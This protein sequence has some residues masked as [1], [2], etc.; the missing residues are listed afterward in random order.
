LHA[1]Q[2]WWDHILSPT[3]HNPYLRT[4]YNEY[5][6]GSWRICCPVKILAE[7]S[8]CKAHHMT[9]I[10]SV[11]SNKGLNASD[12]SG[13]RSR[14]EYQIQAASHPQSTVYIVVVERRMDSEFH[15]LTKYTRREPCNNRSDIVVAMNH[16]TL[17]GK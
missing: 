16:E 2:V 8:W 5:A 7:A 1:L 4:Q 13:F 15:K 3:I 10:S 6:N 17:P 12:P 11:S 14:Y 9:N